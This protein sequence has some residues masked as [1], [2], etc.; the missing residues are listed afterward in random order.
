MTAYTTGFE[1]PYPQ[2]TDLV[3]DGATAMQNLATQVDT[4][5]GYLVNR[6][7]IINGNMQVWQRA[8]SVAAITA[9]GYYTADRWF[10]NLATLGTWTQSR[11][12]DVPT[13]QGFGY[14]LKMDNTVAD[15][16]P[17]AADE[18]K[19]VQ[20]I[21]GQNL[22][23]VLKGTASARP[24]TLSFWVKTTTSGTMIVELEDTNTRKVSA[25]VTTTA[26]TWVYATVTFP[27]DTTGTIPNTNGVG[28][29]VNFWIGAG[30]NFTSGGSLQTTWGTA[31]NT[32]AFGQT[33]WA[34]STAYNVWITGVQ[35]EVGNADTPFEREPI[36]A[37]LAKCL[38]YYWHAT[39]PK[40]AGVAVGAPSASGVVR[41]G[42]NLPVQ[43]RTS[44]VASLTGTVDVYDGN[45]TGTITALTN[46]Y[47][48]DSTFEF[49]ANNAT[50][51]FT[52]QNPA[53][54]Y[55]G[56]NTGSFRLSA[57]LP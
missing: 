26:N 21:E 49:D 37:T 23:N 16:A 27:A 5:M 42:C 11:D 36:S 1:I 12:T 15:A 20:M 46:L 4:Q 48:T 50:G 6:N 17:A 31:T 18:L 19:I 40:M 43:M 3:K 47:Y 28:L 44:P 7:F 55:N 54:T 56:P 52:L 53:V 2:G 25:A 14:S 10:T 30:S 22:Q 38:R 13:G 34:A 39:K 29:Y 32:R 8:T 33:N 51:V 57:E 41:M 24:L 45:A 35:L 9:N